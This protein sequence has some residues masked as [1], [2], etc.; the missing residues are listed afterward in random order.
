MERFV[1]EACPKEKA[2]HS[3]YMVYDWPWLVM[4]GDSFYIQGNYHVVKERWHDVIDGRPA[5]I[6]EV[7]ADEQDINRLMEHG[8][9]RS[10]KEALAAA[11]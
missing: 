3:A 5:L 9:Y 11:S 1:V 10:A 6:V 8:W 2:D 4:I 7:E